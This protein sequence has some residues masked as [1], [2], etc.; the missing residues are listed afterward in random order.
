MTSSTPVTVIDYGAGNLLS[1]RHAV[2]R[3][4]HHVEMATT[5][6]EIASAEILI[7]PGVGAFPSAMARLTDAGLD[8]AIREF[9]A[10][11]QPLLG[12]CLGMQLLAE[13]GEEFGIHPGLGIIPGRVAR[14]PDAGA[15]G[16]RLRVPFVGWAAVRR[17]D[18]S[19]GVSATDVLAEGPFVY[20][21]HSFGFLPTS[22]DDVLATYRRGD[23]EIVAAVARGNVLGVQFHPER[24]GEAGLRFLSEFLAGRTQG[25]PSRA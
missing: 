7:L 9:A 13:V 24:S 10:G 25:G 16:G 15:D 6:D 8:E 11:G 19:P 5:P 2:E 4:G 23:G 21:V 12:I 22:P 14:I 17:A 3:C 1:V 20:F 18:A